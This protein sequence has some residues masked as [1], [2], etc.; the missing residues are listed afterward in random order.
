MLDERRLE[1]IDGQILQER[2]RADAGPFGKYFL[3]VSGTHAHMRGDLVQSRLFGH[4][5]CDKM[6]RCFNLGIRMGI[7]HVENYDGSPGTATRFLRYY[8]R[9]FQKQIAVFVVI[10]IMIVPAIPQDE[11]D[12]LNALYSYGILDSEAESDFDELVKLAST[13]CDTPISLI[14]LIDKDRQWFKSKL[15]IEGT[16]TPREVAFCAHAIHQDSLM[17]VP[18]A[19]KDV[20]FDHNPLV[21]GAPDIRFYAG[22]PLSTPS[23]FKLGTL[24]VID[25]KPRELTPEQISALEILG[26]HVM[27]LMEL[28]R[29]NEEMKRLGELHKRLLSIIGHDLR[30]PINNI[31]SM[32]A[33]ATEHDLSS[34]ELMGMLPGLKKSVD[35]TS[36]LLSNLLE[37]ASSQLHARTIFKKPLPLMKMAHSLIESNQP[38]FQAKS[39]RVINVIQADHIALGDRYMTD[40]IL[41]NLL[42]NANKFTENGTITLSSEMSGESVIVTISD[43][44][45]GIDATILPHVF[46][47]DVKTSTTG[48]Q[49]EKGSGLGLPMSYEFAHSQEAT[50]TAESTVGSGSR[51]SLTLPIA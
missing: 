47:W 37:W 46:D 50:L 29:R 38:L 39:N 10:G 36:L 13:I 14:T 43:T 48:S 9:S 12:R 40:F 51:F 49:G 8:N 44:G 34:E 20:R 5:R 32:I 25:S 42:M 23:G 4:M 45:P 24:C 2:F 11:A 30:S 19:T 6:N 22:M 15:G 41:R 17:V 3:K 33:L 28:R 26:N 21:T 1:R 31:R 7:R 35:S 27:K 16:E 18:D